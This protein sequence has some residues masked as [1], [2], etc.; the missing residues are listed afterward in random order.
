MIDGHGVFKYIQIE[1]IPKNKDSGEQNHLIVRGWSDCGYH[2]QILDKFIK[3]EL[4]KNQE[5]AQKYTAEC[6]GGGR[7]RHDEANKKIEIY[8]Y[9]QGF[10]RCDHQIT[11][12]FIQQEYPDYEVTWSNEGY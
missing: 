10:G 8:G 5:L 4:L 9:S 2:A 1:V 6:P 3:K 7:I 12:G 11:Q